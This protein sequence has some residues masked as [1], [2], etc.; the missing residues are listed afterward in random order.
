MCSG[1]SGAAQHSQCNQMWKLLSLGN[2]AAAA[3]GGNSTFSNP[4]IRH[5]RNKAKTK[6]NST[7]KMMTRLR[8]SAGAQEV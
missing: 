3:E 4:F 1:T 8:L 6:T 5:S 7:Q 2:G